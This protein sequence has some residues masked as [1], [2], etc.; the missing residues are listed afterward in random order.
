[1]KRILHLPLKKIYFE[2]I[3]LGIKKEEYRLQN[4]YWSKRLENREYDEIH[5]KLGYPKHDDSER[6]IIVPWLGVTKKTIN[7]EHFFGIA[8]VFAIKIDIQ[9][10]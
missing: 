2:Q 10:K 5:I 8:D 4:E 1:M 7:H 6:I 3:K 9:G